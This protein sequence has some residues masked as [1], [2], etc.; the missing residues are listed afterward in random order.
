MIKFLENIKLAI[1]AIW[2]KKIRSGLTMLGVIIGVFAI[3][4]LVGIGEGVKSQVVGQIQSL[5]SN[6]IFV[7]PGSMGQGGSSFGAIA[8][9]T[10]TEKDVDSVKGVEGVKTVVPITIVGLPLSKEPPQLANEK[11]KTSSLDIGEGFSQ[12]SAII[13]GSTA[14]IEEVFTGSVT[15]GAAVGRMFN[16]QEYEQKAR[17]AVI[18]SGVRD[19]YFTNQTSE[20]VLGQS[21]YIGKEKFE[22][23]AVK[24]AQKTG[25]MFGSNEFSNLIIIPFTTAQEITKSNEIHRIA[26]SVKATEKVDQVKDS[27]KTVLLENHEGVNDFSVLTPDDLLKMFSQI[28][29]ILKTMLGGIAAISLLVGGIGVM[30]IMLV[31]VTERTKEIGLRKAIG[32]S[33]SDVLT[34]FL[35]EAVFLTFLGGAIGV[36]LAFIGKIIM[37][38][39][40]GFSPV[41]NLQSVIMA[42]G[43][44]VLIGVFFGVTPAIRAA[45]LDPIKALKYE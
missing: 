4:L 41:I 39:R 36:G 9:S 38:V 2:G 14:Q 44:T 40:F 10:L 16:Q 37:D 6:I 29:D 20:Q 43:F 8:S 27:V 24:E 12:T 18:F 30:N 21:I 31:S 15:S 35:V 7:I 5:G 3:V 28:L 45:R 19:I 11:S 26:I 42:F 23:I 34:Q 33:G 25:N 1:K 13:F 22:I 32:A 17:V